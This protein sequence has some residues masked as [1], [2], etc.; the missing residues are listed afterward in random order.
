M[1]NQHTKK[2]APKNNHITSAT[3]TLVTR[4]PTTVKRAVEAE[5]KAEGVSP[6]DVVRGA[7]A[8]DLKRR[9]YQLAPET[10]EASGL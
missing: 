3:E 4:I 2:K 1:A 7:L 5:A 6:A 9:G 8:R 10:R